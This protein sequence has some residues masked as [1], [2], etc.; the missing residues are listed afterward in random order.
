MFSYLLR[1]GLTCFL[2]FLPTNLFTF[3]KNIKQIFINTKPPYRRTHIVITERLSKSKKHFTRMK[4]KKKI[5]FLI[6][7]SPKSNNFTSA[8]CRSASSLNLAS[9]FF[10]RSWASLSRDALTAQ[11][12]VKTQNSLLLWTLDAQ[13][14]LTQKR[15]ICRKIPFVHR[16]IITKKNWTMAIESDSARYSR[17]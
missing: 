10:D 4:F 14:Y 3:M 15:E 5:F 11:P 13:N 12:I 1:V 16:L 6:V 7:H 2:C 8:A 9:I 17:R